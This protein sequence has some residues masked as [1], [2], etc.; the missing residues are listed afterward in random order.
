M[1]K[2][3]VPKKNTSFFLRKKGSTVHSEFFSQILFDFKKSISVPIEL[4]VSERLLMPSSSPEFLLWWVIFKIT[5]E[6]R[7]FS[8]FPWK[9][10]MYNSFFTNLF[11][12]N[13]LVSR[14]IF[15]KFSGKTPGA[16]F[17]PQFSFRMVIFSFRP[18][19]RFCVC[20]PD[21]L[22][23][24]RD[25]CDVTHSLKQA[26]IHTSH[27]HASKSCTRYSLQV[28]LHLV[29][30]PA[31]TNVIMLYAVKCSLFVVGPFL[32]R[33]LHKSWSTGG[34]NVTKLLGVPKRTRWHMNFFH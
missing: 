1:A 6:F 3:W 32:C 19:F 12:Y 15:L 28:S 18:E 27:V 13:T 24:A 23:V 21:L 25:S 22:K 29:N 7:F 34:E 2:R 14:S 33:T 5:A 17:L 4:K 31:H 11:D 30:Q 26:G 9:R 10:S 20:F 16:I 8:P